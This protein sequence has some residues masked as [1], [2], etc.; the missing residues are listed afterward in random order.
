MDKLNQALTDLSD[1][2]QALHAVDTHI[3]EDIEDNRTCRTVL[4]RQ[5]MAD[6][7]TLKAAE[8]EAWQSVVVRSPASREGGAQ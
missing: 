4:S 6:L 5:L 7:A 2:V 3:I 8:R 1:T